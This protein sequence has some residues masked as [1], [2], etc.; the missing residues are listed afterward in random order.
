MTILGFL[1]PKSGAARL[2]NVR[3][4]RLQDLFFV[5]MYNIVR[6]YAAQLIFRSLAGDDSRCFFCRVNGSTCISCSSNVLISF[7]SLV[8]PLLIS[9]L[10]FEYCMD[11]NR[12]G[13]LTICH[14]LGVGAK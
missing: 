10:Q 8:R 3:S 6:E 12:W 9:C 5:F 11:L 7:P 1:P 2:C 4:P 13:K 14:Y